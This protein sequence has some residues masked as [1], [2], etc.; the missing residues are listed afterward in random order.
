M[1]RVTQQT[2]QASQAVGRP[3]STLHTSFSFCSLVV[4]VVG[5]VREVRAARSYW[6]QDRL[7]LERQQGSPRLEDVLPARV[8][9]ECPKGLSVVFSTVWVRA[10]AFTHNCCVML[11]QCA[12]L[13]ASGLSERP[14]WGH[15]ARTLAPESPVHSKHDESAPT[16]S[17]TRAS[18]FASCYSA[19]KWTEQSDLIGLL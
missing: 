15:S 3:R 6:P 13:C 9:A 11:G 16:S 17:G 7:F 2:G 12:P 14:G 5:L 19:M 4:C 10:G 1:P 18:G 8:G